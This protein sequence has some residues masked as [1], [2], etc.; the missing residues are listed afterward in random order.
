MCLPN[1]LSLQ[2]CQLNDNFFVPSQQFFLPNI[3]NNFG[4]CM[5]VGGINAYSL[6]DEGNPSGFELYYLV[7]NLDN[8]NHPTLCFPSC[9]HRLSR[10]PN[11]NCLYASNSYTTPRKETS[12]SILKATI[13]SG[14]PLMLTSTYC[15]L[16]WSF[17]PLVFLKILSQFLLLGLDM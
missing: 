4:K 8:M 14:L 11:V 2:Q 10:N 5:V 15:P 17:C 16:H 6:E 3:V 7:D 13:G 1:P 12:S 9:Y